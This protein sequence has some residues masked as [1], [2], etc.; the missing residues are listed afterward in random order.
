V[1]ASEQAAVERATDLGSKRALA[2]RFAQHRSAQILI[3][4]AG[5]VAVARLALAATAPAT[6]GSLGVVD[7][8]VIAVGIGLIGVVEWFAHRVLFHAP[9]DSRRSRILNTGGSHRRHHADPTDM[10]W[11]LLHPRGAR[12][13]MLAVA[14]LVVVW[15][16][17]AAIV[18]GASPIGPY[19]T[20]VAVAWFAIANYEWT[21]LLAHS[22][23]RPHTRYYRRLVR[24]HRIHHFRDPEALYG[25]SSNLGDRLFATMPSGEA[26]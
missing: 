15:S 13:L 17:P 20:A 22:S 21:H 6:V 5:V 26:A 8:V 12:A 10:G 14:I 11:V 1:V 7:V 3:V 23:Y 2:R 18:A 19:L 4:S 16:V 25:I 24:N 9:E